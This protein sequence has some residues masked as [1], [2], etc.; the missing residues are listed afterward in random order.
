LAF[1]VRYELILSRIVSPDQEEMHRM[2]L[3]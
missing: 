2:S 1:M 3:E